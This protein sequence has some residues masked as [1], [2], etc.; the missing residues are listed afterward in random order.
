MIIVS[1][2]KIDEKIVSIPEVKTIM[3]DIKTKLS[4]ID[5]NEEMSHFQEI[6]YNYVNIFAKMSEKEAIKIRNFLVEKYELEEMFAVN[7][8]NI[9]PET[10]PE[11]RVI[12]EKS[13]VGKTLSDDQLQEMLYQINELKS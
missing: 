2:R 10:V 4:E 5:P 7:I 8:V 6:T 11:L 12:L 9:D 13:F 1:G 3:E